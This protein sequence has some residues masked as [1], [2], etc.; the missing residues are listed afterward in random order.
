MP[1]PSIGLPISFSDIQTEFGGDNPIGIDEYYQNAVPGYTSG[2]IEIPNIG[3]LISM[4]MFYG[5]SKTA[6]PYVEYMFAENRSATMTGGTTFIS[7]LTD[8]NFANI[9][10]VGNFFW[11]GTNWGL[12]NNVQW[13]TN[14]ALTFGGGSGQYVQWTPA[15]GKGILLGQTD[16]MTN[17]ANQWEPYT[18]KNHL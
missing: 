11:Y 7:A 15:T 13:C 18:D 6:P 4:N 9:G 14:N 10:T 12:S 16:R 17:W 2:V 5:K 8:D 3:A 1:T